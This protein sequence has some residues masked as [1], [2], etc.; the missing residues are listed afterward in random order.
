MQTALTS[1]LRL[2]P[3]ADARGKRAKQKDLELL[4]INI[5]VSEKRPAS[6]DSLIWK[7]GRFVDCPGAPLWIK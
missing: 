3:S 2:S 6:R 4:N 1:Y 5:I 7:K